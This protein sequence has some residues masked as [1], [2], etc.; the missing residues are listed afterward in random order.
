MSEQA[1]LATVLKRTEMFYQFAV[2]GAPILERRIHKGSIAVAGLE[3]KF[4]NGNMFSLVAFGRRLLSDG[5]L[6]R[7]VYREELD[8]YRYHQGG[9]KLPEWAL[10]AL[11]LEGA[12]GIPISKRVVD[13]IDSI[14]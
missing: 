12:E 11:T 9:I 3:A 1:S 13:P 10:P 4:V 8:L 14:W 6:G 2:E 7:Q 5:T